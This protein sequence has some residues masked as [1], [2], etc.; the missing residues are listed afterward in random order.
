MYNHRSACKGRRTW[1]LDGATDP[2]DIAY[3]LYNSAK[4]GNRYLYYL[5]HAIASS[6]ATDTMV[7]QHQHQQF[8]YGTN[9]L[10]I[11]RARKKL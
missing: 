6:V 9:P 3:F 10:F 1:I 8:N 5:Q 7:P 4:G 2:S 11:N